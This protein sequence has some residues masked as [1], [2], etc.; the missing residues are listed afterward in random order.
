VAG[1][2]RLVVVVS[3]VPALWERIEDLIVFGKD[4]L[5]GDAQVLACR[6]PGGEGS[7]QPPGPTQ[8]RVCSSSISSRVEGRETSPTYSMRAGSHRT[9]YSV[10]VRFGVAQ[11]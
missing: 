4:A 6:D 2:D 3:H 10:A 8:V 11:V 7:A 5:S 9:R 1:A